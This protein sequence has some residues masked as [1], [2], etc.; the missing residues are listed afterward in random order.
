MKQLRW[1]GRHESEVLDGSGKRIDY[2][3]G[4][5]NVY[6]MRVRHGLE[7]KFA[8]IQKD[9]TEIPTGFEE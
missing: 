8:P 4:R 5:E 2:A 1:L 6:A 7:P 3:K 9:S